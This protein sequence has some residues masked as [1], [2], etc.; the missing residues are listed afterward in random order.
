MVGSHWLD[1]TIIAARRGG[2]GAAGGGGESVIKSLL[3]SMFQ[4]GKKFVLVQRRPVRFG[5]KFDNDVV[6]Y[7]GRVC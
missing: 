2:S 4:V 3:V 6:H 5:G 1:Q 7:C